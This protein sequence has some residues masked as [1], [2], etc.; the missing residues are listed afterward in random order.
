M[1]WETTEEFEF[2]L[3]KGADGQTGDTINVKTAKAKSGEDAAFDVT[4]GKAGTYYYTI[5]ETPGKTENLSY[6]TE[7]KWAKVVVSG[8]SGAD[9]KVDSIRYGASKDE[10]DSD[11][12][13]DK[14]VVYNVYTVPALEKYINKDV[15]QN[16]PAYDTSFTYDI[17]A[18]VTKDANRVVISDSLAAK[19]GIRFLNGAN[20][21]VTVQEIGETNDH[22][23]HGTVEKAKGRKIE[24]TTKIDGKSLT[25]DIDNKDNVQGL[26]GKWVRVT[27]DVVLDNEIV[28]DESGYVANDDNVERNG[29]VTS[30]EYPNGTKEEPSHDGVATTAS[31]VV[32]AQ[33]ADGKDVTYSLD[34]NTIT[35]TPPTVRIEVAKQWKDASGATVEWPKDAKVTIELIRAGEKTGKTVTLD[36]GHTSGSF[37]GM[38]VYENVSFE[39]DEAS[40]QGVTRGFTT[41]VTGDKEKGFVLTNTYVS[42]QTTRVRISKVDVANGKELKGA[43][44]QILDKDG[45][46][47]TEWVSDED[48]HEVEGLQVGQTYILRETVAPDG[49]DV[50][51]DIE[52]TINNDGS[53]STAGK[54][55]TD[56]N[57]NVVLLVEDAKKG[58]T[59]VA[60]DG[61][62]TTRTG[63]S[64][65]GVTSTNGTTASTSGTTG[66][67]GTSGTTG[68]TTSTR[69]SSGSSLAKTGDPTTLGGLV[70]LVFGGMGIGT[71]V[72]AKLHRRRRNRG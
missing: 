35:V 68:S 36:A 71:G 45:N 43:H 39:V 33:G 47:I 25:V 23:A 55:T 59:P 69:T 66:S 26:R 54:T 3:A 64:T 27:Y 15:H 70:A 5:T 72:A 29:T 10:V 53:V 8:G 40:V 7:A 9:Y 46:V 56:A 58:T 61:S 38:P 44:L 17:L 1:P 19:Q 11:Q 41:A 65:N 30:S 14:L 13:L 52:F 62:T 37:E 24:A 12:A 2:T 57:G 67:T 42:E 50:T 31:Y 6:D 51:T 4:F 63:T 48:I 16:L 21:R 34:A 22:K 20:T 49:Y 60:R 28:G 18:F 32:Y